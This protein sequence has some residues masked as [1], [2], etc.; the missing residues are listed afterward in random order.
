MERNSRPHCCLTEIVKAKKITK[1]AVLLVMVLFFEMPDTLQTVVVC[2]Y[3]VMMY[4][5][6]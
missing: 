1:L 6:R 4:M 5:Q 3:S 2:V